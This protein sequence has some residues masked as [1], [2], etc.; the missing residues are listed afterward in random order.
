V[1]FR[2]Q[3]MY[4]EVLVPLVLLL[5]QADR[6][7]FTLKEAIPMIQSAIMLLGDAV[8][9]QS[10]LR[11]T[12]LMKHLNRLQSLM[13]DS[14]FKGA[15]PFIFGE[16]FGEK[17]KAKLEAAAALKKTIGPPANSWVFGQANLTRATGAIRV[18]NPTITALENQRSRQQQGQMTSVRIIIV[19]TI[20]ANF[21]RMCQPYP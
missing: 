17:A 21:N 8:Q 13:K 15:Q 4:M 18:A 19:N 6:E 9:H 16:D 10:S 3:E 7:D 12:E 1:A 5:D 20:Y 14:D 11:R 2:T